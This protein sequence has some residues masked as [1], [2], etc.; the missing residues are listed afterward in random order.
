[1]W[2]SECQKPLTKWQ[3]NEILGSWRTRIEGH[4]LVMHHAARLAKS[5]ASLHELRKIQTALQLI[6]GQSKPTHFISDFNHP[7][8]CNGNDVCNCTIQSAAWHSQQPGLVIKNMLNEV[9]HSDRINPNLVAKVQLVR[10]TWSCIYRTT[11]SIWLKVHQFTIHRNHRKKSL[12]LTH[13]NSPTMSC[14]RYSQESQRIRR[15][16]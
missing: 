13:M 15:W 11:F 12:Q 7:T 4:D 9:N 16:K 5:M 14:S 10:K 2:M 8:K 1:M 6:L 3:H